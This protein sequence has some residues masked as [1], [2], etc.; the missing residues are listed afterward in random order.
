MSAIPRLAKTSQAPIAHQDSPKV[1][2]T[3]RQLRTLSS[4]LD[5]VISPNGWC[6]A[7]KSRLSVEE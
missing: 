1:E 5:G 2:G 7:E 6:K 4:D 3:L